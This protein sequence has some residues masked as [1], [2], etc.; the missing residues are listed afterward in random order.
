L[1]LSYLNAF[2]LLFLKDL[3]IEVKTKEGISA[4]IVFTLLTLILFSM[5]V[6]GGSTN[7][8]LL[9]GIYWVSVAF[10]SILGFDRSVHRDAENKTQ[11][12]LLLVPVD[13]SVLFLSKWAFN[14]IL[15]DFLQVITLFTLTILFNLSLLPTVFLSILGIS[16]LISV[17]FSATGTLYATISQ[18]TRA[19]ELLLPLLFLPIVLPLLMAGIK[20]GGAL[21]G[22]GGD[23]GTSWLIIVLLF[24]L[25]YLSLGIWLYEQ[26]V[27]D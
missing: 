10:S 9:A 6:E 25:L 26:V 8:T 27:V 12:A 22:E 15:V 14:F 2:L 7:P 19:K 21:L 23:F 24:D 17:G 16:F 4:T 13:R 18:K 11:E 3:K 5:V 1:N 20:I